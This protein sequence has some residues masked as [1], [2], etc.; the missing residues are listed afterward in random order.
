[1][2]FT[3]NINPA[4]VI[5]K[6]AFGGTFFRDIYSNV[7]SKF[8]K[9]SWKEY[10]ELEGIDKKYYSSD[11]YDVELNCYSAEVGTSLRF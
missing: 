5:K 10:K 11:F 6:G 8:Y 9:N 3:P 7:T 2:E 4:D 1:M